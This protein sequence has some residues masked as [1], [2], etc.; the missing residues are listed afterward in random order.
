M[1]TEE[2]LERRLQDKKLMDCIFMVM[3]EVQSI[4]NHLGIEPVW[5]QR[6]DEHCEHMMS[7]LY[8]RPTGNPNWNPRTNKED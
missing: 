3:A 5:K 4:Q 1:T 2:E 7:F 6:K 8:E